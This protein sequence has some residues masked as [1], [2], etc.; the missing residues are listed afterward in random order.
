MTQKD[1]ADRLG[2]RCATVSAIISRP[3]FPTL[4]RIAAALDME[5]WQLLAPP[6]L[7]DAMSKRDEGAPA[8]SLVGVVRAGDQTYTANNLDDLR[9]IVRTIE[10]QTAAT[11]AGLSPVTS[12]SPSRTR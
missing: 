10:S 11:P 1:L 2:V 5:P 8:C 9:A 7:V 4:E 3:S 12:P 6:A